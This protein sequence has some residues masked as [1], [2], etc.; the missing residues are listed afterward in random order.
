MGKGRNSHL[1]GK[2]DEALCRRFYYWTD[3]QRIRFDDVLKILSEDEFFISEQR[4]LLI[5]RDKY[6]SKKY[7]SEFL[8]LKKKGDSTHWDLFK[9]GL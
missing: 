3:V 9:D 4:V 8:K 7:A 2:R 5:I 1:I 6:D